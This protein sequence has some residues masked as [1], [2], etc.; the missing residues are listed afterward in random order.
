MHTDRSID[1]RR[2]HRL[3]RECRVKIRRLRFTA[4]FEQFKRLC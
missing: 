4:V 1:I 2:F 3:P